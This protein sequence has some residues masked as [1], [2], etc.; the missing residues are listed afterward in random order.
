[1]RRSC[2]KRRDDTACLAEPHNCAYA[3]QLSGE[4]T[5][6]ERSETIVAA[7][8][9]ARVRCGT[10]PTFLH[11]TVGFETANDPV[12]IPGLERDRAVGVIDDVLPYAVP[13]TALGMTVGRSG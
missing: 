8:L 2:G 3:L 11:D 5:F 1:M 10:M 6:A 7:P 9:V 12:Q 13:S 4:H